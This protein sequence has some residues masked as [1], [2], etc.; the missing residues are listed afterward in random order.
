MGI[1]GHV[2]LEPGL[3]Y[4]VPHSG[5][6]E[7][8]TPTLPRLLPGAVC[9][10]SLAVLPRANCMAESTWPWP[11]G[12]PRLLDRGGCCLDM[13]LLCLCESLWVPGSVSWLEP[14]VG[15]EEVWAM[16]WG[17][18]SLSLA[19]FGERSDLRS[20]R[21]LF[22]LGKHNFQ[23]AKLNILYLTVSYFDL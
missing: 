2:Y 12:S 13:K 10:S 22:E 8:P 20:P 17:V 18:N 1:R 7:V 23:V 5:I 14:R 11:E 16:S 9:S 19:L 21:D 15:R 4:S 6:P 3:P